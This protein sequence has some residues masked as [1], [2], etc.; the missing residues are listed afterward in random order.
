LGSPKGTQLGHS[1]LR[2]GP[3]DGAK[4]A[5]I[6]ALGKKL[7]PLIQDLSLDP[8]AFRASSVLST[9]YDKEGYTLLRRGNFTGRSTALSKSASTALSKD[10][11]TRDKHEARIESKFCLAC[12]F[13]L[14]IALSSSSAACQAPISKDFEVIDGVLTE[15]SSPA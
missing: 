8:R 4:K 13:L 3:E 7:K 14:Q 12:N 1:L 15:N 6:G 5:K 2:K 11:K 10:T 9:I